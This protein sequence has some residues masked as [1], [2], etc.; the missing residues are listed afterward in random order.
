MKRQTITYSGTG[1]HFQNG[2]AERAIQTVTYWARTMMLH[3]VIHWPDRANLELWPFA[4]EHAVYLWNNLPKKTSRLA[5]LE[6]FGS[7][8]FSS[9]N[10]LRRTRVWGCPVYV[11]DATLQDGKKL[12]KWSPRSRRG[13]YLGVSSQH[14]STI[15]RI[16]NLA[17]GY[18][19]PQYHVVYDDKFSSVPNAEG[20]GLFPDVEPFNAVC[21]S[22]WSKAVWNDILRLKTTRRPDCGSSHSC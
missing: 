16:L 17:T 7:T 5:P 18:V 4:L 10:H 12:P 1:A 14:S 19:S 6:I 20:G 13:Q 22:H 15:G 3:A 8:Q 2:V 11:L 21:W 9:Y